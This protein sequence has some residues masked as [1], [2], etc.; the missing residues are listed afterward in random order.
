MYLT[1]FHHRGFNAVSVAHVRST[2]SKGVLSSDQ[3]GMKL[4]DGLGRFWAG[5]ERLD[6]RLHAE[7][8]T[9]M[10]FWHVSLADTYTAAHFGNFSQIQ[11]H[12]P[13]QWR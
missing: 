11:N 10:R 8:V 1:F 12:T 4:G 13:V 7:M 9:D 2:N 5:R 6:F 3:L